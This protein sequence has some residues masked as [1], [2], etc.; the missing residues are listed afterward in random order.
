MEIWEA[1]IER[2]ARKHRVYVWEENKTYASVVAEIPHYSSDN[3]YHKRQTARARLIAAAPDLLEALI[4]LF[5]D[6]KSLAD[7]GDAGNWALEE[8][9]VGIQA[10]AAIRK[11]TEAAS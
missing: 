11:A 6:Y 2:D 7:S 10:V 8:Q 4:A 5:D 3:E 1:A 9:P